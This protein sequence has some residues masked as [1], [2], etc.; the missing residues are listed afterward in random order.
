MERAVTATWTE[1][2]AGA[3]AVTIIIV[4]VISVVIGV[5][6]NNLKRNHRKTQTQLDGTQ[7][8]INDLTASV[9]EMKASMSTLAGGIRAQRDREIARRC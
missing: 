8:V 5:F 2:L 4:A 3:S 1:L 6:F 7:F 9:A